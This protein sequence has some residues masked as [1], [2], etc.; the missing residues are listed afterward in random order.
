[1]AQ[2]AASF[3]KDHFD[4]APDVVASAPGR[5]EFIGNH[6]DYNGGLVIGGAI[7]RRTTV[8]V[9]RRSDGAVHL[10]SDRFDSHVL[11]IEANEIES[12]RDDWTRYPIA[13]LRAISTT[14]PVGGLDIAVCSNLDV[15]AGLSSSAALEMATA[16]AVS[17]MWELSM[18]TAGLVAASHRAE[19]EFVGV[20]CG[21]LDQTVVGYGRS[22]R[23]VMLDASDNS[24]RLLPIDRATKVFLLVT[25]ETHALSNSLYGVRRGECGEALQLLARPIPGLSRLTELHPF[26]LAAYGGLL[27]DNL[28]RRARHV[29]EENERVRRAASSTDPAEIGRLLFAS[30]ASSRDLFEN[31]TDALDFIVACLEKTP[32]IIG[33]RLTGGGFGGAALAW[34]DSSVTDKDLE[35]IVRAYDERFSRRLEVLS[36]N[37]SDG[38]R[39]DSGPGPR[40]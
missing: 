26:D 2:H 27:P 33:G 13:V 16:Q 20:P 5:I 15:G 17:A 28:L 39:I 14:R 12:P 23:L 37:W 32:G 34:T 29:V 18:D 1:M 36:V 38:V 25:H 11:V 4:A 30:H 31:S 6:T 35:H 19:T 3:Y 40:A 22:D 8:A 9:G 24:H 10:V 21:L 7:D